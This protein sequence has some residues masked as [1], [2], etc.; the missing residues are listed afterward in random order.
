LAASV[1]ALRRAA[2]W[3]VSGGWGPSPYPEP[4]GRDPRSTA[5]PRRCRPLTDPGS[6]ADQ[7]GD[8]CVSQRRDGLL[9]SA[10]RVLRLSGKWGSSVC[11]R[12]GRR[13]P[14]RVQSRVAHVTARAGQT[15]LRPQ[16]RG[17]H[18]LLRGRITVAS[19]EGVGSEMSKTI[20]GSRMATCELGLW[21]F[22]A[23]LRGGR[24]ATGNGEGPE[25]ET[26][27]SRAGPQGEEHT[28]E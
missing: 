14:V 8:G 2:G 25:A 10:L 28:Y 1:H 23:A 7:C 19:Q 12:H 3:G 24:P 6:T 27:G 26:V 11:F 20:R 5:R 21:S 15:T 9:C 18:R 17:R 4:G 16:R 22:F 13:G